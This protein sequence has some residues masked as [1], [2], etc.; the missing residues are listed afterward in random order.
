[1]SLKQATGKTYYIETYGCQM[2]I[3][4]TEL[5]A[6]ILQKEN[7]KPVS[8][9]ESADVIF[10]NTCSIREHAE[11]KV[12]SRLGQFRKRK[13]KKPST[14]IG[15]LGCMAQNLKEDILKNKPYVDIVLGPDSYRRIPEF[16]HREKY[17]ENSL[18]DT[19]LS[20]IEVYE[21]L[22]PS[23]NDGINAWIS[24]MRGCDKFCTFCI[25]PLLEAENEAGPFRALLTKQNTQWNRAS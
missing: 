8:S 1:M 9:F 23:R 14:I 5:V 6:G 3:Y 17:Q 20:R 21:D 11:D 2:N 13:E 22:F 15:V 10:V 25:V 18:V 12:H 19:H 24:I 16:L 4:D 7:Y